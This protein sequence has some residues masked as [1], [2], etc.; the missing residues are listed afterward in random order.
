MKTRIENIPEELK[1]VPQWVC[2]VGN[3]KI[4]KNPHTGG[5]AMANTPSTW[6]TYDEAVEACKKYGFDYLGFEFGNGYFG[7]DLDHCL[8][9]EKLCD[10]FVETLR[11]YTELS[12]SGSGIHI[13][14]KGKIPKGGRRKGNVEMYSEGR[15]F[16]CTGN[17]YNEEYKDIVDCT[18]TI[19]FLHEKYLPTKE[20]KKE[21]KKQITVD[22]EDYEVIDKARHCKSG[23][24]FNI[25][26]SGEWES[27]FS[28]QSEA[29]LS[30][31]NHLAF[32]TG[33]NAVQMDRIFRSSG[34]MRDKWDRKTG[35]DT[36]GSITIQRA[37]ASCVDVYE[38][39]ENVSDLAIRFF[40]GGE[41]FGVKS[42][43]IYN[44]TDTGNAHRLYDKF[45]NIIRYSYNRKKWYFWDD[46]KWVLDEVGM[47][48]TMADQVC[49]DLH[50]EALLEQDEE[51]RKVASKFAYKTES[52]NNK[53]AMIK[54]CQH[55]FN[56]PA[57]PDDFDTRKDYLNCFNG[58]INLKNG[59]LIPHDSSLMMTK[60]CYAEYDPQH[61]KPEMWLQFL[62]D[63][64]NGNK[65]LQEYIQRCVGYSISG[66]TE[67]QCVYF[68]Y[69]MGNNG[70]STFLDTIADLLG[71]Y[72]ANTQPES[73]M[74]HSKLGGTG[75][76]SDIARLKSARFVTSEEPTEG[77]RLN[78]GLIKQLTGG[79][80]ITC[81][82]LYGDEFEYNPEFK[83]W[84][85]TNH[86]PVI[87]GTDLGIWRRIKL[88]PFEVNIPADKVDKNLKYKLRKEFPQI[89]A[90]AVDGC[91]KWQKYG[92]EEPACVTEATQ[93]YKQEMD[94]IAGFVEQCL[95]IDYDS[96][97]RIMASDLFTLY[98]KWAKANNEWEMSSKKFFMEARKR[99]PETNRNSKGVFYTSI[100]LSEYAESLGGRQYRFEDFK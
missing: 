3:D 29:D 88:I 82:F 75:A 50:K 28:S 55:L 10:D 15:Y 12:K 66:S 47:I 11:S 24:V 56:I 41:Q 45:G 38:G 62:D 51:L 83:I 90:W 52:H 72:S 69:G 8:D 94:L 77:V 92:I 13:I 57:S 99:L 60:I 31:C 34:L 30:L 96:R 2:A 49:E 86:K 61:N 80:K 39:Q 22:L 6:G 42:A 91:L 43:K 64:T 16:I 93:E 26:Y 17:L 27:L 54:E 36:Y 71:D 46:R 4:P 78:E 59:E 81:R 5:N 33:R 87:R 19:K 37:I 70:K 20:P 58:V 97:E 9:D 89:L 68:L 53:E 25:L 95:I 100:K 98:S 32:W 23:Q 73:L 65:E 14:C 74:I 1:K 84:I 21:I 7:V 85:A 76:N 67:E 48:K 44:K 18:D 40:R 35:S 79:S 63:V